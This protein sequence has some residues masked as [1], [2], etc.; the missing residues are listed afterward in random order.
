MYAAIDIGTNTALLLISELRNGRIRVLHED[1]RLPRLGRGVDESRRLSEEAIERA[2]DALGSFRR[3]IDSQFTD[4]DRCI[5]T[6]TSAVR[7][8]ENR[9]KL[10]NR[11]KRETGFDIKILSGEEEAAWTYAGALS[12]LPA[13]GDRQH[14]VIDIGGGSTELATGKGTNLTDFHSFDI[15]SVRFS[16][17]FLKTDPPTDEEIQKCGHAIREAFEGHLFTFDEAVRAV[18][19]AG[20][21]TSLAYIDLG[22]TEYSSEKLANYRLAGDRVHYWI[23]RLREMPSKEILDAYP[24]VM[25]GR[26]DVILAGLLILQGFISFYE[27]KELVVSTGGIRHGAVLKMAEKEKGRRPN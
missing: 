1:Q 25:K 10:K 26:A 21:V 17:R 7:D 23:E 20:T 27:F 9:D 19:V 15:G 14:M 8:A 13:P 11:V 5:V 16:E 4:V 24:V 18:G 22:L 2:V 12:V 6:A 3:V